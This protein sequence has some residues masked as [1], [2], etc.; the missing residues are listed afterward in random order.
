[1][2]LKAYT[3]LSFCSA[4]RAS[5]PRQDGRPSGRRF[6]LRVFHFETLYALPKQLLLWLSILSSER[7]VPGMARNHQVFVRLYHADYA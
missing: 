3:F 4:T 2:M 7:N 5:S 1:M 6:Q